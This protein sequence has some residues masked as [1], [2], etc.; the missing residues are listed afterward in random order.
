VSAMR[1]NGCRDKLRT[2]GSGVDTKNDAIEDFVWATSEQAKLRALSLYVIRSIVKKHGG[3]IDVD[4]ATD[5]IK[6]NVPKSE[7]LV[8]A[9]EIEQQIGSMCF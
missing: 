7:E 5:T 6:I 4:L 9:R 2:S 3:T 8:C 1:E